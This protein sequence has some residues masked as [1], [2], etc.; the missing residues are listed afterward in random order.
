MASK[1]Q[2]NNNKTKHKLNEELYSNKSVVLNQVAN[3]VL[4]RMAVLYQL[5]GG[6]AFSGEV[7]A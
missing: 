7:S 2:P 1:Q 5:L 6:P 3:G 4:V